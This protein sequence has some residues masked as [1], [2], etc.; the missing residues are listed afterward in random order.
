MLIY[1]RLLAVRNGK[2]GFAAPRGSRAAGPFFD[3]FFRFHHT[4]RLHVFSRFLD[5]AECLVDRAESRH[6]RVGIAPV[7]SLARMLLTTPR[8]CSARDTAGEATRRRISWAGQH[9]P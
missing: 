1:T 5:G 4:H 9:V 3:D 7:Q 2:E 8:A 6:P